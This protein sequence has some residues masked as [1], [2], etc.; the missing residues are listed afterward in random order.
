MSNRN[1]DSRVIIQRLQQKNYARNLYQNNMTGQR[2]INNPQNTDGNSSRFNSYVPGAQTDYFRGLVG[3]G[4]TVSPGGII[5]IPAILP[6]PT[7]IQPIPPTPTILKYNT[8]QGLS[9]LWGSVTFTLDAS[10][11][12]FSYTAITTS[13][14][15]SQVPSQGNLIGVTI[16]NSVTSIG[17]QAFQNAALTSVIFTP[18]STLT[19]IGNQAFFSCTSLAS[20]TIPNSVT[21]IGNN[22]FNGCFGLTSIIIGN[23]VTSIGASAFASCSMTIIIIPSSVT[24][25][26]EGTFQSC[27]SL[28][29]ITIP[30]SVTSIG[31]FAF[32]NC[33][34]LTS[35]I[36]G[37]SVTSIGTEAFQG[38]NNVGFTSITI[39]NSVT[40]IGD[41][42]FLNSG[43]LIVT[44]S[45]ATAT[46]LT[47][48]LPDPTITSP[49]ANPPG[50]AFFGAT[51]TTIL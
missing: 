32:S 48:Q 38:C 47:P 3:A 5:G 40:S 22:A 43:L 20:I 25:I 8:S 21:S 50:V 18:T 29:S 1:F 51:V 7:P 26:A 39:P 4:E 17:S 35:I 2:L 12:N 31:N 49:T 6:T 19:I 11:P 24:S 13:I 14:P 9:V 36:I 23:S 44:I 34:N 42:A 27:T 30:N 10:L 37:N 28:T 16:G 33:F 41:D 45:S 46:A 15:G